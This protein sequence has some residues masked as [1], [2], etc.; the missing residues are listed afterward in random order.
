MNHENTELISKKDLLEVTGISY[1]QLYRWKRKGLIPD[2]WFIKK[3]TFTGQETFFP[4]DKV[5]ARVEKIKSMKE[6]TSLDDLAELFSPTPN[7]LQLSAEELT[8]RNIVTN[9]ALELYLD[10]RGSRRSLNFSDALSV[11]IL[12]RLLL[13]GSINAEEGLQTLE[14]LRDGAAALQGAQSDLLLFRKMGVFCCFMVSPPCRFCTD[15]GVHIIEQISLSA[16][17]EE[18]R[19]KLI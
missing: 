17:T 4:K 5:L 10:F 2:R 14:V 13:S 15:K 19:L 7:H 11:F 12:N 3:S 16:I 6:G 9:H 18:L 8:R 1:G